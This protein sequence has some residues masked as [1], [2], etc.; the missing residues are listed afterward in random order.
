[1]TISNPENTSYKTIV[2]WYQNAYDTGNASDACYLQGMGFYDVAGDNRG[3]NFYTSSG[4]N[5]YSTF[6]V[7]VYGFKA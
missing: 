3:I 2:Q 4:D 1:M 6:T 5:F 7:T